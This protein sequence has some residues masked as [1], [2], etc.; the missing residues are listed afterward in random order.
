MWSFYAAHDDG[1]FPPRWR[2]TAD[3]GLS[4]F[5]RYPGDPAWF[6]GRRVDFLGRSLDVLPD[7]EPVSVLRGYLSAARTK[8]ARELAAK[9][10]ILIS[11]ELVV[12]KIVWPRT[13]SPEDRRA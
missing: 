8:S 12:G 7:A 5:G 6:S 2:K 9:A 13:G 11:P 10:V 1:E 4:K 3:F